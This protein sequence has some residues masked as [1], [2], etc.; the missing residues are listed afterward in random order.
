[1]KVTYRDAGVD[2]KKVKKVHETIGD[3]IASTHK[4]RGVLSGYGHYAGLMEINNM[5]LAMHTDGVG[6]KVLVA[7]MASKFD[8]V[9][10]DCVAMNVNDIIC[11]GAEPLAFVDYIAVRK[12][13]E[14]LVREIMR[15]LVKGAKEANVAIIGGETAIMPDVISGY[16]R[17]FDIA[18]T[19]V[20]MVEKDRIVLGDRIAVNDL[21]IGV[22]SNGL[23]SNGY[24]LV[25]RVL[26]RKYSI[27][28]RVGELE[29]TLAE[30]LLKPTRIYVRPVMEVLKKMHVHGL[31]HITGGAFTK[32][33][34]LTNL[35]FE[36]EMPESPAI[37]KLIQKH[38]RLNEREM[39][40][41]FNMGIGFCIVIPE[42][43]ENSVRRIFR[44]YGMN[45][46]VIGRIGGKGVY[47]GRTR[48][49]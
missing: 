39:Y 32:L 6:T 43:Y 1:V 31:A 21:V 15:G 2:I 23:H 36:L 49:A 34:R 14:K 12:A 30:E 4:V 47:I 3:L 16:K 13:D 45:S 18:G 7:Q 9:G 38:T 44:R 26:L 28:E 20:G 24:S 37:F 5:A 25:R 22:E 41:T 33:S 27:S 35:G 10:I 40:S 46:H 19:V 48:L 11:V 17:A 29:T 42:G 8:T